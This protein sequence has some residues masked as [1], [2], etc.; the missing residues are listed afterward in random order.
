MSP[1]VQDRERGVAAVEFALVVPLLLVLIMAI[2][3][4]GFRYEK[5]TVANNAALIAARD[6]SINHDVAKA[7]AAA[8][9]AG[10]PSAASVTIDKTATTCVSGASVTVTITATMASV[11]KAFGS[12]FPISGKAVAR[13]DGA[14]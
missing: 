9:A 8:I 2:V 12:T 11:T 3:E 14:P 5:N 6:M 1:G 7:K 13:C 10:V 4:F